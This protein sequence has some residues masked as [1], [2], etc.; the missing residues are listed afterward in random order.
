[1]SKKYPNDINN[2]KEIIKTATLKEFRYNKDGIVVEVLGGFFKKFKY[3]FYY[4]DYELPQ[5]EQVY[6]F[7]E[8][9]L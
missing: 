7:G 6:C 2:V 4:Y 9:K 5:D 1:M 8:I 3:I